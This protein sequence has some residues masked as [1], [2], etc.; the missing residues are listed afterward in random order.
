MKKSLMIENEER[1]KMNIK[2]FDL[3][4]DLERLE[5][6]LRIQYMK[7]KNMTSWLPERLHDLIYRMDTY[8][9]DKIWR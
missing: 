8:Y 2:N 6:F 7:N 9:I 1:K 4:S 5:N 3:E